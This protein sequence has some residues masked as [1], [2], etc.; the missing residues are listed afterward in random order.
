MVMIKNSIFIVEDDQPISEVLE[1]LLVGEGYRVSLARNGDEALRFLRNA[2]ELP[3]LIL[4]DLM[5]P[6]KD[7]MEFRKEQL[8]DPRLAQIPV[9]VMSADRN[10]DQKLLEMQGNAYIRKPLSI[11]QLINA[12]SKYCQTAQIP[13]VQETDSSSSQEAAV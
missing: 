4:L 11:E 5:M 8:E 9:I 1:E 10:V 13:L 12:V 3:D 6:V 2:K 7:G